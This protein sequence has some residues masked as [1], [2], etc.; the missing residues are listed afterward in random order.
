MTIINLLTWSRGKSPARTNLSV[1]VLIP[2][3]DE[4]LNIKACIDAVMASDYPIH[5]VVVYDDQSTDRTPAILRELS[6][7]HSALE[8]ITG[9]PLPPGWIGKPH[10]CHK[11]AQAATGEVL[12]FVDS[13][14]LLEPDGISRLISLLDPR[15]GRAA[16][17]VTAFPR[18]V[19]LSAP[20]RWMIPLLALT[21]T[22]WFPLFLVAWS[23]NRRFLAANGQLLM[24]RRSRYD[25]IGG[26]QAVAREI[27]DDMALCRLAKRMRARVVFAD[28]FHIA[29]CR[30]YRSAPEL[31]AGFTKN[32]YEGIGESPFALAVVLSL[33]GA[34]FVWPYPAAVVA[35]LGLGGGALR[36][37]LVGVAANLCVRGLL[38]LR[39]SHPLSSVLVHPLAVVGLMVLSVHSFW[40][41]V[42][43]AVSWRGRIYSARR[44]R[45]AP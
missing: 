23:R 22:S 26:F 16:D 19:M 31:W 27:V 12:L 43:N 8:V 34:V 1:S 3:R 32:L 24:I 42:T 38:A 30:M 5:Q 28:G 15:R 36:W 33:Y 18:Q 45:V 44:N 29:R 37:P 39:L 4:E 20:E 14:T 10:A 11:L 13:D 2:A 25:A 6:A 17:L 40:L 21:Y 35:A 7:R 9:G 41:N